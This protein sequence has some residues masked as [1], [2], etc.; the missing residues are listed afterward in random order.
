MRPFRIMNSS[1]NYQMATKVPHLINLHLIHNLNS[2]Y[3]REQ[4]LS[5]QLRFEYTD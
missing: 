2:E 3:S 5:F 4:L 1:L